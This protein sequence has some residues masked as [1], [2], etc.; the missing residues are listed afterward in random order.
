VESPI[1]AEPSPLN[2]AMHTDTNN[3]E[4]QFVIELGAPAEYAHDA[5]FESSIH[6]RGRHWDGDHTFPFSTSIDGLWLRAAHLT[7][8]REHVTRWLRQPLEGLV[9]GD[10]SADFQLARLPGQSVHVRFGPRPD[11]I[12]NLNPVVSITFSAGALQGEFHFV[13]DQSCL[14]LFAQELS[15]EIVGSHEAAV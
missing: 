2:Y 5:G 13:T 4:A 11:T 14:R 3:G 6:L 9:A 15:D 8:L 10:L 12:S 1:D 7:A